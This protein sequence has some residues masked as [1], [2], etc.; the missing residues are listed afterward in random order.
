[1]Q[2]NIVIA[3]ICLVIVSL[4]A[5]IAVAEPIDDEAE[6]VCASESLKSIQDCAICCASRD[7]LRFKREAF[8]VDHKC[9]CYLH[10]SHAKEI[11]SL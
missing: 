1:M 4:A 11:N 8:L 6:S 5:M 10:E 9:V 7:Y 3:A 2:R